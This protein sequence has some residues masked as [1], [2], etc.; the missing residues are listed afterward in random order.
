MTIKELRQQ[1][2]ELQQQKVEAKATL[3]SV[4]GAIQL[5]E[6]WLKKVETVKTNNVK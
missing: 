2:V 6:Y 1:L 3:D 5:C 4:I